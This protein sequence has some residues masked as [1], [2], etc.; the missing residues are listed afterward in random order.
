MSYSLGNIYLWLM[1]KYYQ[2]QSQY[3]HTGKIALCCIGKMENEYILE[4]VKYYKSLNFDKIFI[5]DNNDVDGERFEEVIQGYVDDGFV[6]IVDFRGRKMCQCDAYQDCYD[7]H[8]KEYDWI[9]FFDCDE[10]L[11][12][13]DGIQDVHEFMRQKKFSPYQLMHI[14]WMVYGDNDML[15]N[16][17]RGIV[18]RFKEPI[19][20]LDFKAN[21]SFPENNHVKSLIRGGLSDIHWNSGYGAS[22]TPLS[23]YYLC[24]NARGENVEANAP[25]HVFDH[26]VAFLRHYST[27]TIGE[28][29]RNKM[30]RGYPD[31]TEERMMI[32]L[33]LDYFY[34]MNKRNEIKEKYAN[35]LI[36]NEI[37][38]YQ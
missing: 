2:R 14:N 37:C 34:R 15:D 38:V 20:P 26:S 32:T 17:G 27:K 35:R 3:T 12:F 36:Q 29:V 10:F 4:Y 7:Q 33:S 5:Y 8:N 28:W 24:C 31:Q 1:H 9:A 30:K 23:R 16:D 11:T 19:M 13:A 18:E 25:H 21:M 6:C 22:H